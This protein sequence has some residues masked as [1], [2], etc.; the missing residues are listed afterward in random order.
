MVA[1]LVAPDGKTVALHRTYLTRDGKKAEVPSVKKL[2]A[3]A[4]PLPGACIPLCKPARGV[5]GIAEG[6]ETALAASFASGVPT[7]AAYSAGNLAAWH[8]P[9]GLQSLVVFADNDKAGAEAADT[10]R[11]RALAAS[12]RVQVLTPSEPGADWCDVWAERGA[13]SI[14]GAGA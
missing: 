9:A 12:L 6:I 14:E 10:L 3:T 4:G 5:L 11:A 2:T 13:V 8:W 7:V 1:P